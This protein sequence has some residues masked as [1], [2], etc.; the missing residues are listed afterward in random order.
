MEFTPRACPKPGCTGT[1]ELECRGERALVEA[2]A[3]G[4]CSDCGQHYE[5]ELIIESAEELLPIDNAEMQCR[6]KL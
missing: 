1:V 2:S 5:A 6:G 4:Q 3:C